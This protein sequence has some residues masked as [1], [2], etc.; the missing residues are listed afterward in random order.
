[1]IDTLFRRVAADHGWTDAAQVAVLLRYAAHT[2]SAAMLQA[3]LD[4]ERG[5]ANDD[6]PFQDAVIAILRDPGLVLDASFRRYCAGC[7]DLLTPRQAAE[8]W[9]CW[10]AA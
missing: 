7:R 10:R 2:G 5:A 8:R 4:R 9:C 3:F 1:M 6:D